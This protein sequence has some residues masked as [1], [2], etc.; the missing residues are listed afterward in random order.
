MGLAG[1]AKGACTRGQYVN[2]FQDGLSEH[3][4][5][6][7][8]CSKCVV[9]QYQASGHVPL[10]NIH[11]FKLHAVLYS[12]KLPSTATPHP[13]IVVIS[14]QCGGVKR[15]GGSGSIRPVLFSTHTRTFR[16][17]CSSCIL[18]GTKLPIHHPEAPISVVVL[19]R[20]GFS[21]LSDNSVVD[22]LTSAGR[23]IA[24][25][26][27]VQQPAA[28]RPGTVP[29]AHRPGAERVP[30]LSRR[31]IPCLPAAAFLS[32]QCL[33]AAH[34]IR[35]VPHFLKV[36]MFVLRPRGCTRELC[37]SLRSRGSI[38]CRYRL[39][40]IQPCVTVPSFL[41]QGQFHQQ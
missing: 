30:G 3:F 40:Q 1:I 28:V 18:Y 38:R 39:G 6:A 23:G 36:C 10:G 11:F 21:M 16:P 41:T 27:A 34:F 26:Q 20:C 37:R 9:G 22:Q 12:Y 14:H 17:L 15:S 32:G 19:L 29:R 4:A 24:P 7:R 35:G 31:P 2:S 8:G 13:M 5:D 33:S 25:E